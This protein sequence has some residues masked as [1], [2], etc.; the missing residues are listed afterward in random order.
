MKGVF[1]PQTGPFLFSCF[2]RF[3]FGY[4]NVH[5]LYTCTLYCSVQLASGTNKINS[6]IIT[7]DSSTIHYHSPNVHINVATGNIPNAVLYP[8]NNRWVTDR[9]AD[10]EI[11]ELSILLIGHNTSACTFPRSRGYQKA[12]LHV[13]L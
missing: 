11:D 10:T 1:P 2:S 8:V 5:V 12:L 9:R 4:F 6:P 3:S 7:V 13:A